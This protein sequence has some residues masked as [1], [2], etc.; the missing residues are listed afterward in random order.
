MID[1]TMV[2]IVDAL[3]R[4]FARQ[5]SLKSDLLI[6]D[7]IDGLWNIHEEGSLMMGVS[8]WSL[9]A[10]TVLSAAHKPERTGHWLNSSARWISL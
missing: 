1:E 6:E 7:A 5:M 9:V 4:Y 3:F 2:R 8:P 10:R